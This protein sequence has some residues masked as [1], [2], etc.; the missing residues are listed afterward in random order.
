MV[1][2]ISYNMEVE[3]NLWHKM[4]FFCKMPTLSCSFVYR[5]PDYT[6]LY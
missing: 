6:K 4:Y 5:P 2:F 1:I 3:M